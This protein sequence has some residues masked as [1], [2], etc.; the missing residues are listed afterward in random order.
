MLTT[1]SQD[2]KSRAHQSLSKARQQ[3]PS[4][5]GV[6]RECLAQRKRSQPA[7]HEAIVLGQKRVHRPLSAISEKTAV[8]AP[9]SSSQLGRPAFFGA[10]DRSR[11]QNLLLTRCNRTGTSGGWR[12]PWQR[13]ERK[14]VQLTRKL[15]S[16]G[17]TVISFFT[18][19]SGG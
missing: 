8:A 7:S 19:P 6:R 4:N 11:S 3:P 15:R 18:E 14:L 12:R 2:D 5:C 13:S 9:E 10:S 16:P 1:L 17:L